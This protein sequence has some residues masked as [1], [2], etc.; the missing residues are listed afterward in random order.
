M[1]PFCDFCRLD[2][3]TSLLQPSSGRV[4]LI[5]PP[6]LTLLSDRTVSST[7]ARFA[8]TRQ[9]R[10]QTAASSAILHYQTFSRTLMRAQRFLHGRYYFQLF[11]F[12]CLR[13]ESR[14]P[15][16]CCCQHTLID[17]STQ[18]SRFAGA[19]SM[20]FAGVPGVDCVLLL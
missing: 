17:R 9:R 11:E 6:A 5:S 19:Q 14:R 7:C 1:E 8:I 16:C 15:L 18:S 2:V 20:W 12:I 3:F 4:V 13:G 10:K